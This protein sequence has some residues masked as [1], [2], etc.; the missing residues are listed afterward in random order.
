MDFVLKKFVSFLMMPF[1]LGMIL[2]FIGIVLLY[3]NRTQKA[4]IVFILSFVWFSLISYSPIVNYFLYS[5]ESRIPTLH[6]AP[7]NIKY[8]YILG[9]GHHTDTSQP[10]TSQVNPIAVVRLVEG[11]RL[12]HQ[13]LEEPILIVSGY[14][15]LQDPTSHAQMQKKLALSL[16]VKASKIHIEPSAKDTQEEARL[17]KKFIG[18]HPFILVTS[19]SHMPRAL[20]FFANEGL[21]PILAPTNHLVS[22]QKVD[23]LGI[24]G[25]GTLVNTHIFWHEILGVLWQKLKGI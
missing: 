23:Y 14:S 17:A 19:A 5:Y 22:V 8:I 9:N 1:S 18:E 24:Y 3:L 25:V 4:K 15:G 11:I 2:L 10:I 20:S 21:S 16:G 6:T 13:L 12:Y 7:E